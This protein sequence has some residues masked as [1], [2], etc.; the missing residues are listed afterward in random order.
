MELHTSNSSYFLARRRGSKSYE[1]MSRGWWVRLATINQAI[2]VVKTDV[3]L[4][5][6]RNLTSHPKLLFSIRSMVINESLTILEICDMPNGG[7]GCCANHFIAPR[8][9]PIRLIP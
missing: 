3:N 9:I 4:V 8:R 2:C 6:G 7:S 1:H 5:V